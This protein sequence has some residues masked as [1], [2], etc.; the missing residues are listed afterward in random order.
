LASDPKPLSTPF[1]HPVLGPAEALLDDRSKARGSLFLALAFIALGLLGIYQGSGDIAGGAAVFGGLYVLGGIVLGLYGLRGA[2]TAGRSV[3]RRVSLVVGRDGFDYAGWPGPVGWEEVESIGDP[4]SL[5]RPRAIR[6]QLTHPDDFVHRHA[7]NVLDRIRLSANRNEMFL[8]N[9]TVMPVID[10]QTMMRKRLAEFRHEEYKP[11]AP[12]A[13]VPR[14]A[15]PRP[16]AG[17]PPPR[18][19]RGARRR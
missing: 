12:R 3:L 18:E 19:R 2:M 14:V 4:A 13:A 17:N 5:D 7:L 16:R 6:V 9:G 11:D 1:N 8:G 10:V 15:P